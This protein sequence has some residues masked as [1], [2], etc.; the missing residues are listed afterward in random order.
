M[1]ARNLRDVDSFLREKARIT[2]PL[3]RVQKM[4]EGEAYREQLSQ[5][6]NQVTAEREKLEQMLQTLNPIWETA[7]PL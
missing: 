3:V 4:A 1:I 6:Q 5:L 7:P 2:S